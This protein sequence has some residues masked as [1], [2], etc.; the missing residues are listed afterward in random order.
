MVMEAEKVSQREPEIHHMQDR[1]TP[2]DYLKEL[3]KN[4]K[5]AA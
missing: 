4:G 1:N 2:E 3:H 5:I